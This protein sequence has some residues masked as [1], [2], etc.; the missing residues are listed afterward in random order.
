MT[1]N[2]SDTRVKVESFYKLHPNDQLDSLGQHLSSTLERIFFGLLSNLSCFKDYFKDK[3][4]K[5][6]SETN[7][8]RYSDIFQKLLS[9]NGLARV[10]QS[11]GKQNQKLWND[12]QMNFI[13]RVLEC[14]DGFND[15]KYSE[16]FIG[17]NVQQCISELKQAGSFE[18]NEAKLTLKKL[19][20]LL[21]L[22]K[23]CK[24]SH[25]N[26]ATFTHVLNILATQG[27]LKNIDLDRLQ[28]LIRTLGS[29]YKKDQDTTK[30]SLEAF[31]LLSH[32]T[33]NIPDKTSVEA[34]TILVKSSAFPNIVDVAMQAPEKER[35]PMLQKVIEMEITQAQLP[36][37]AEAPALCD[38]QT[39]QDVNLNLN[40]RSYNQFIE[41]QIAILGFPKLRAML[42]SVVAPIKVTADRPFHKHPSYPDVAAFLTQLRGIHE[43]FESLGL[44]RLFSEILQVI[45]Q[46]GT[47]LEELCQKLSKHPRLPD[48][49]ALSEEA[50]KYEPKDEKDNFVAF[51]T[52]RIFS[53]SNLAYLKKEFNKS[54]FNAFFSDLVELLK[55]PE[56]A[57]R[58]FFTK[59]LQAGDQHLK[60]M[61][62]KL[63]NTMSELNRIKPTLQQFG[64]AQW[65][66][67]Q[68]VNC[69]NDITSIA[70]IEAE[71]R[72]YLWDWKRVEE[73]LTELK[74][75]CGRCS[76][77]EAMGYRDK[78]LH[79]L[80]YEFASKLS[81]NESKIVS[82]KI[83]SVIQILQALIE[84]AQERIA[85]IRAKWGKSA[86]I[87]TLIRST[88]DHN[89]LFNIHQL[90]LLLENISSF[91]AGQK[92]VNIYED[93]RSQLEAIGPSFAGL[94]NNYLRMHGPADQWRFLEA[95]FEVKLKLLLGTIARRY[96][97]TESTV[98]HVLQGATATTIEVQLG[99]FIRFESWRKAL[100]PK[101]AV[102]A[103]YPFLRALGEHLPANPKDEHFR[104]IKTLYD[105]Y[106]EVVKNLR[107]YQPQDA[108]SVAEEAFQLLIHSIPY[109][110]TPN[111]T[112]IIFQDLLENKQRAIAFREYLFKAYLHDYFCKHITP[113]S[114]LPASDIQAFAFSVA[115]I[116]SST[117]TFFTLDKGLQTRVMK[118]VDVAIHCYNAWYEEKEKNPDVGYLPS[119]IVM[120]LREHFKNT[121]Q[122]VNMSRIRV[123]V[124]Q[125]IGS[126]EIEQIQTDSRKRGDLIRRGKEEIDLGKLTKAIS[127]DPCKLLSVLLFSPF[128]ALV[129]P[130]EKRELDK[131]RT[132]LE[133]RADALNT[134][135]KTSSVQA[136]LKLIPDFSGSIFTVDAGA[137]RKQ[138]WDALF[139]TLDKTL[140]RNIQA[141]QGDNEE[142]MTP[143]VKKGLDNFLDI[144]KTNVFV[145][146]KEADPNET[147]EEKWTREKQETIAKG[148]QRAAW[149]GGW[150]RPL[151]TFAYN[152]L[153]A[154]ITIVKWLRTPILYAI[155]KALFLG[156]ELETPIVIDLKQSKDEIEK[157]EKAQQRQKATKELIGP[158]LEALF[159]LPVLGIEKVLHNHPAEIYD[160]YL[161]YLLTMLSTNKVDDKTFKL[162]ALQF[163]RAFAKDIQKDTLIFEGF[164]KGLYEAF[165]KNE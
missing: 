133:S 103:C 109:E 1:I 76:A 145:Q 140:E 71:L 62:P 77:Y 58:K 124:T 159:D 115:D 21:I 8:E 2:R 164:C 104:A 149:H 84:P 112:A 99:D 110:K 57:L 66:K 147:K 42:E 31:L 98:K 81:G 3:A 132:N 108:Y 150:I 12:E 49:Y 79:D 75:R 114:T 121:D 83:P 146:K 125:Q 130:E 65:I 26:N 154:L 155:R 44:Q 153:P 127:E 23:I 9:D 161:H 15:L 60:S 50:N 29:K 35:V 11:F 160:N 14:E 34:L 82:E 24:E 13:F 16:M 90:E 158:L 73:P 86:E 92:R 111:G 37:K 113:K 152:S 139:I 93:L 61:H 72:G 39:L 69:E 87:D 18:D 40:Q 22:A 78:V 136:Y 120:E 4:V 101:S 163:C 33:F 138:G 144:I 148:I 137:L 106:Q 91:E 80:C 96:Q 19:Q 123:N 85:K 88:L 118:I 135:L 156:M 100:D 27:N 119:H 117:S 17:T 48:V 126:Q 51:V 157:Q 74:T 122:S 59:E 102:E 52:A 30:Q 97:V 105:R 28:S 64:L 95:P 116:F 10:N 47:T 143:L 5:A 53:A 38:A 141:V 36:P 43:V 54:V 162:Q 70:S 134:L 94:A 151:L 45:S 63:F 131:L 165:P 41:D 55:M 107:G 25:I 6:I 129:N 67:N 56:S 68:R 20:L 89:S 32:P 128:S 46:P 142:G 7:L